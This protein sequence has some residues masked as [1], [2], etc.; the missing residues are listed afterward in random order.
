[1]AQRP[2][3]KRLLTSA[4]FGNFMQPTAIKIKNA[5]EPTSG[6]NRPL[7]MDFEE[8]LLGSHQQQRARTTAARF[9]RPP[10][11]SGR[12]AAQCPPK[13]LCMAGK[14]PEGLSPDR[15]QCLRPHGPDPGGPDHLSVAIK[16]S[17][18]KSPFDGSDSCGPPLKMSCAGCRMMTRASNM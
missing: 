18:E 15:T 2:V 7:K 11:A 3:P 10:T 17:R 5:P 13:F 8:Q 6:S 14:A 1:M 16:T 4:H 9:C 12:P